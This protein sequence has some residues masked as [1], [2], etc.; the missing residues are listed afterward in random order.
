[1][2]TYCI[3]GKS[4]PYTTQLPTDSKGSY[5]QYLERRT[6]RISG[7]FFSSSLWPHVPPFCTLGTN[8]YANI[9]VLDF[10]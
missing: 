4:T 9:P 3:T 8:R 2:D 1:M 10:S 5:V 7:L 6:E